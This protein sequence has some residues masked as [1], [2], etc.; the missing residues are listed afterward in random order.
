VVL[1]VLG[2]QVLLLALLLL[3]PQVV[4]AGGQ[5]LQQV[6]QEVQAVLVGEELEMAFLL[7]QDQLI[8]VVGAVAEQQ[9]WHL[10]LVAQVL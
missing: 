9:V 10:V 8:L 5:V 6:A 3:T 1:A 2:Y 7:Q 4:E